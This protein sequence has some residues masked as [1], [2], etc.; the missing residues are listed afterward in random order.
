MIIP[1]K[2]CTCGMLIA[3]IY[4][5]YK[6]KVLAKKTENLN[7]SDLENTEYFTLQNT[8]KSIEGNILDELGIRRQCCRTAMLTH[9]DI[10]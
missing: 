2:C 6:E 4:R 10:E 8:E 1:I 5:H 7:K 3:D 9:V